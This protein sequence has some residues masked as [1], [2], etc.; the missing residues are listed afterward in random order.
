MSSDYT[1]H[2]RTSSRKTSLSSPLEH[3]PTFLPPTSTSTSRNASPIRKPL[4]D[5]SNSQTNQYSGPTIRI[6]EDPGSDIYSKYPVPSEPSQ[7][8]PP[9]RH[10]PGYG[11]ERPGS[12]VSSG[13]QVANTI[14]KFERSQASKI[15]AQQ[16]L[17]PLLLARKKKFRHSAS[18]RT[19][20]AD[21]LVAS[22]LTPSSLRFSQGST[23]PSSPPPDISDFEKGLEV[24]QEEPP[25][26]A[27]K[28]TIRAV[29][30]S[31]S[32]GESLE[33][34]TRALTPQESGAS[35]ASPEPPSS[36]TLIS[37]DGNS[38]SVNWALPKSHKHNPSSGSEKGRIAYPGDADYRQPVLRPSPSQ[39]SFAL[40]DISYTS[41]EPTHH[42]VPSSQPSPTLHEAR[43]ATFTS[44]VRINY[45]IVR[46]PSASSLRAESQNIPNFASRMQD[47]SLVHQWSSQLSTIPSVSERDSRSLARGSRSYTR[48]QSQDSYNGNGNSN[49]RTNYP[50]RRGQTIG[51]A[52]SSTDNISAESEGRTEYSA[53]PMP[54]FS[55]VSRESFE[56]KDQHDEHLDTISPLPTSVPLRM[57]NSGYLR[58]HNSDS[59]SN[60]ESRPGSAQSDI[61]TFFHNSIPAWARVYY[62]R[63]ERISMGAPGSESSESLRLG[64]AHSGRTQTP[65]EGNFPLSIYRPRNRPRNRA[66]QQDTISLADDIQSIDGVYVLG[67]NMHPLSG[68]STPHLRTDRRGGTRY[69]VWAAPSLDDDLGSTLFGRQNRQILLFCVG[70]LFPL[71]WMIASFLPLP[72]DPNLAEARSQTDLEQQFARNIG[73]IDD[74]AF[75]KATWWRN[76][77]RVMSGIGTLLIGVIIALAIL[78]SRM[79]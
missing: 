69:S 49:G 15:P 58:R 66:S 51:S 74:K 5:R 30:P 23:P 40:S 6:V 72:L 2:H 11:F 56:E 46:A 60:T 35:F 41:I 21:T 78:V 68:Y 37:N 3:A 73:A 57:K 13:S 53:M 71:A 27:Q 65:S 12:R 16:P 61:S 14:A 7:I 26:L 70:F 48:S 4:H 42:T 8:L 1:T 29:P 54:L 43:T 62:Q 24:L 36:P 17:P 18:T 75:Q 22:S 19:S 20:E 67:P 76:L 55:P 28:S 44:G 38:T 39:T 34:R 45:P 50:R 33:S 77:N 47:R 9:P 64:T 25:R 32:G 59:G 79:S 63:G 31:S 10:A 52:Q